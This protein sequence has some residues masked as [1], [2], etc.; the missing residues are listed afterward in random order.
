MGDFPAFA[1]RE[2]TTVRKIGI[3][4]AANMGEAAK[5]S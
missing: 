2:L 1:L 3:M 5:C 4:I